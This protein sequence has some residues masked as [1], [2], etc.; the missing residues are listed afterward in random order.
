MASIDSLIRGVLRTA[1]NTP[2]SFQMILSSKGT[3]MQQTSQ[4]QRTLLSKNLH[5]LIRS[6]Y[7][8][9]WVI[10]D[11]QNTLSMSLYNEEYRNFKAYLSAWKCPSWFIPLFHLFFMS[12]IYC[13]LFIPHLTLT[14]GVRKNSTRMQSYQLSKSQVSQDS[15][16]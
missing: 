13:D 6:I 10:T 5:G 14:T 1:S 16:P 8:P 3:E 11:A 15:T 9:P 2:T 7:I 12:M 4:N